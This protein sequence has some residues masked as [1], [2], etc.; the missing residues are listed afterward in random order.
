ML[1]SLIL[2]TLTG[3]SPHGL[4]A[5]YSAY[6]VAPSSVKIAWDESYNGLNDGI[7]AVLVG[8]FYVY[9]SDTSAPLNNIKLEITSGTAGVCLVPA[10]A[11]NT[12]DYPGMPDGA[13]MADCIDENGNFDNQTN[14]WCGWNYDTI[15]GQFY[16]FGS[17]YAGVDGF[18]PN[19]QTGV[20]DRYGLLRIYL[21]IDALVQ[22]SG[23]TTTGGTTTGGTDTGGTGGGGGGGGSSTPPASRMLRSS[24]AP[25]IPKTISRSAPAR[26]TRSSRP[27]QATRCTS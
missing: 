18:C 22:T 20:T 12:V 15:S 27:S 3:C 6:V 19:L 8:N 2:A 24:L 25:A 17:D 26:T 10:E 21:Y 9:D 4:Q 7:G 11:L 13:S 14:E 5:P 16:Q 1:A 23:G